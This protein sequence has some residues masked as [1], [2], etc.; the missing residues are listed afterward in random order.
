[1]RSCDAPVSLSIALLAGGIA[2]AI[3]SDEKLRVDNRLVTQVGELG[4]LL[5]L[6]IC[7]ERFLAQTRETYRSPPSAP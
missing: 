4:E 5:V 2:C 3:L 6:S 7:G 1:V